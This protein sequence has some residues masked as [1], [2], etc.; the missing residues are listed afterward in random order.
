MNL[1]LRKAVYQPMELKLDGED[2]EIILHIPAPT[3]AGWDNFM[4]AEEEAIAERKMKDWHKQAALLI[5]NSNSDGMEFAQE[6]LSGLPVQACRELVNAYTGWVKG[7]L[8]N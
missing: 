3:V 7:T 8:K 1:D 6:D 4:A 2:G 5:L